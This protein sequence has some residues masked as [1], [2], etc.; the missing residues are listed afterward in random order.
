[1]DTEEL[2][3][4]INIYSVMRRVNRSAENEYKQRLTERLNGSGLQGMSFQELQAMYL[5]IH[6]Q[7]GRSKPGCNHKS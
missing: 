6:L 4:W 1:M 7:R 3:V 2:R 5:D